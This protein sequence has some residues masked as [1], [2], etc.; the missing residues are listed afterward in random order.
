MDKFIESLTFN[1]NVKII[2]YDDE[3][4][5]GYVDIYTPSYDSYDNEEEIAIL[6]IEKRLLLME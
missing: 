5:K 4:L 3:L 6:T 2:F 1:K